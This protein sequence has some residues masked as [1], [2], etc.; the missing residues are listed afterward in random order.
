MI[1]LVTKNFLRINIYLSFSDIIVLA[2]FYQAFF[3]AS[4]ASAHTIKITG[5]SM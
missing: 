5:I 4:M 3:K 1:K 2:I